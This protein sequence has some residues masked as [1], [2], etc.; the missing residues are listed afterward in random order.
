MGRPRVPPLPTNVVMTDRGTLVEYFL[1]FTGTE[2]SLVIALSTTLPTR[3]DT[4]FYRAYD[5]PVLDGVWRLVVSGGALSTELLDYD[6]ARY[7]GARVF[8]R[9]GLETRALE[10]TVNAGGSLVYTEVDI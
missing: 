2:G 8:A 1:T 5:G 4:R 3:P 6:L 7:Y 9:R 10:I